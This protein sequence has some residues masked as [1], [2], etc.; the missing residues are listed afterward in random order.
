SDFGEEYNVMI[1]VRIFSKLQRE[2]T[3]LLSRVKCVLLFGKFSQAKLGRRV[4]LSAEMSFGRNISIADN[5]EFRG[6]PI[7]IGDNV[8][9]HENVFIRG[10]KVV[11]IGNNTTINRNSC[12]LDNVVIGAYCSIAPNVVIV[13]SNHNFI[14]QNVIIKDQGMNSKGILIEDDVWIAANATILD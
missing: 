12:I 13:G 9:I 6:G 14:S 11:K 3:A 8:L 1:T 2:K 10:K 4:K 5:S 7:I